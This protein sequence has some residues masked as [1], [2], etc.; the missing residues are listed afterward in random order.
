MPITNVVNNKENEMSNSAEHIPVHEPAISTSTDAEN[1]VSSNPG[2]A[3]AEATTV[4][5]RPKTKKRGRPSKAR[6]PTTGEAPATEQTTAPDD[7]ISISGLILL[8][9]DIRD[10]PDAKT[11]KRYK[12]TGKDKLP[13]IKIA[14]CPGNNSIHG[15]VLDGM[16]R[17]IAL[18]ALGETTVL[19]QY[20]AVTD[21]AD[22]RAK[23]F[24]ANLEH[25]KHYSFHEKAKEAY[26][27]H[28]I[29]FSQD[30]IARHL[31]VSQATVSRMIRDIAAEE[32]GVV[33][34]KTKKYSDPKQCAKM[35]QKM[36]VELGESGI[37]PEIITQ[38]EALSELVD[39]AAAIP[40]ETET[41]D[42]GNTTGTENTQVAEASPAAT[43]SDN[44]NT[45]VDVASQLSAPE[46]DEISTDDQPE[47]R[48][49]TIDDPTY[50]ATII[51]SAESSASEASL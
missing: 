31:H 11:I 5:E 14:H 50:G 17:L 3:G 27:R 4:T 19:C 29:G 6:I 42:A 25:G 43:P 9:D 47:S 15:K 44:S 32:T 40:A 22:A 41:V 46:N 38:M 26:R 7:E 37:A 2:N 39:A 48:E 35:L 21:E 30:S 1:T 36:A 13:P 28:R 12:A 16:H 51:E 18:K 10:K 33:I 23:A 24:D 49:Q 20:I 34:Q 45:G 8:F